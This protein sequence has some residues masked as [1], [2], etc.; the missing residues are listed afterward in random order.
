MKKNL[1]KASAF[2]GLAISAF[3]LASCGESAEE[4]TEVVNPTTTE[5]LPTTTEEM[6]ET[7]EITDLDGKV[8]TVSETK[9][10]NVV[11]KALLLSALN[12]VKSEKNPYAIAFD[13]A[14]LGS[15]TAKRSAITG[16]LDANVKASVAASIG[17]KPY[18]GFDVT[19]ELTEEEINKAILEVNNIAAVAS[20]KGEVLF[21]DFVI[22]EKD[23][24]FT[25]DPTL[26]DQVKKQ[27]LALAKDKIDADI[28]VF[29]KENTA[30]G[31]FF[32][33]I[34]DAISSKDE[35][36]IHYTPKTE[37]IFNDIAPMV[38]TALSDYQNSSLI[39]FYN[40]YVEMMEFDENA[41]VKLEPI[42]LSMV[43]A[44]FF[45]SEEY[46]R[47]VSFVE[48]LG[49]EISEIKDGVATVSLDITGAKVKNF[50]KLIGQDSIAT[51]V[52]PLL[53]KDE[54]LAKI[55]LTVDLAKARLNHF[56]ISI[57]EIETIGSVAL[58]VAALY[59]PEDAVLPVDSVKGSISLTIDVKYDADINAV[60]EPKEGI[61]YEV[62]EYL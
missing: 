32:A 7:V 6:S 5:T 43:N 50:L 8:F 55:A 2:L 16:T 29:I 61:E 44:E 23:P 3:V 13:A 20:L 56:E 22:D 28:R 40:K 30:Y 51:V 53:P 59:M 27:A 1:L 10:A 18:T 58:V 45:E 25:E 49:I 41:K 38:T 14:L 33:H 17:D 21:S 4:S 9:D 42:D 24:I 26:L 35:S 15:I 37:G 11:T 60:A 62:K 48:T 36:D 46:Q 34:P 54:S 12:G 31:E 52:N 19:K 39:N 57:D 47:I